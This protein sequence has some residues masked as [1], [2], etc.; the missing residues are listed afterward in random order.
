MQK[1]NGNY[2][3]TLLIIAAV[4]AAGMIAFTIIDG[5]K[6]QERLALQSGSS[7]NNLNP[8]YGAS[9]FS[10]TKADGESQLGFSSY[11][12]QASTVEQIDSLAP[13]GRSAFRPS[14]RRACIAASHEQRVLG[15]ERFT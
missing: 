12:W 14:G 11:Q 10:V 13:K 6:L 2:E 7:P 9:Q 3:K 4:L 8:S 15:Q 5:P 1:K